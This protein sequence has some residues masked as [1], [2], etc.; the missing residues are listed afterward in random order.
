M[1]SVTDRH[2][3]CI[4]LLLLLSLLLL[5]LLFLC[6]EEYS[7][8]HATICKRGGFAIQ[9]YDELRNLEAELLSSICSD[10]QMKPLLQEISNEQLS[11]EQI[12]L[13]IHARGFWEKETI[14]VFY[15]RGCFPNAGAC[16]DLELSCI[17]KLHEDEKKR[18]YPKRVNEIE[19]GTSTTLVFTATRDL[20][21]PALS[22]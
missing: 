12:M 20:S 5:L 4:F 19:H 22:C 11:K 2:A 13:E 6:C 16:K 8:E 21:Q 15:K 14:C 1:F 17:Y 9:H 18:K 3:L 10:V 7:V